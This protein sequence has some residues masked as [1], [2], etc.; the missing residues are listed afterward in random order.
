MILLKAE[1]KLLKQT[2]QCHAHNIKIAS[3]SK[4]MVDFIREQ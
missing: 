3:I 2:Y 1:N 4:G